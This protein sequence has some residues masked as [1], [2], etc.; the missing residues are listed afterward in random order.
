MTGI[1]GP[2]PTHGWQ[3]EASEAFAAL[4]E[5]QYLRAAGGWCAPIAPMYDLWR[6]PWETPDRSPFD[7]IDVG[8]WLTPRLD[9]LERAAREVRHRLALARTVLR[10]GALHDDGDDW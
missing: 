5:V 1:D 8:A 9:R 6:Q 3:D 7:H 4:P 10:H 2:R